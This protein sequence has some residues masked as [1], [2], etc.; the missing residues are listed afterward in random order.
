MT[1][2]FCTRQGHHFAGEFRFHG[3]LSNPKSFLM[4]LRVNTLDAHREP[5]RC[6]NLLT[7]IPAVFSQHVSPWPPIPA[8]AR[9]SHCPPSST[10]SAPLRL[11]PTAS[12]AAPE[13]RRAIR[14]F[15]ASRAISFPERN[16]PPAC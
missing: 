1:A 7:L 5:K 9:Q 12:V 13:P 2:L 16:R 6:K 10:P 3:S 8:A 4:S 11:G 15:A 14:E